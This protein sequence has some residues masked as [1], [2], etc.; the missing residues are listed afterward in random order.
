MP[1]GNMK[2]YSK[3]ITAYLDSEGE[4]PQYWSA[5]C[6]G[7]RDD[8]SGLEGKE[9]TL[10]TLT[11]IRELLETEFKQFNEGMCKALETLEQRVDIKL[12]N[13]EQ[14]IDV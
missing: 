10:V 14:K 2:I 6:E 8:R 11:A 3:S 1:G 4:G 13:I 5:T 12:S 9:S 7:L